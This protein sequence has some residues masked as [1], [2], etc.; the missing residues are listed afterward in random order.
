MDLF[1]SSFRSSADP[2]AR[3]QAVVT[4]IEMADKK[5]ASNPLSAS[6]EQDK[7]V[8]EPCG[9]PNRINYRYHLYCLV[10][11]LVMVHLIYHYL[12]FLFP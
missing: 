10:L 7:P 6:D 5:T 12:G 2:A 11:S 3:F 4:H 9:C 8:G 1:L